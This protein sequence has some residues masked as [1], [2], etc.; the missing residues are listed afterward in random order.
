[1]L[2]LFQAADLC[3]AFKRLT[4]LVMH[5][6]T[7]DVT[8]IMTVTFLIVGAG[9][10]GCTA[11]LA[12]ARMPDTRVVLLEKRTAA[13][14]AATSGSE[15]AYP[16]GLNARGLQTVQRLGVKPAGTGVEFHGLILLPQNLCVGGGGVRPC[17]HSTCHG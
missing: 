13:Q 15:R 2:S 7:G 5:A 17:S 11:A 3:T 10:A 12:A 4:R 14:L 6:G 9:P 1:M 16:M 8:C